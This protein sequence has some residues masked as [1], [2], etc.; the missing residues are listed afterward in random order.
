MCSARIRLDKETGWV[1]LSVAFGNKKLQI[2]H[3][4]ASK[5]KKEVENWLTE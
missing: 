5:H 2:S 3:D 4:K 1:S